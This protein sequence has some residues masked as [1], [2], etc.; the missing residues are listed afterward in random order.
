MRG[1]RKRWICGSVY[2]FPTFQLLIWLVS[3]LENSFCGICTHYYLQKMLQAIESQ[4]KIEEYQKYLRWKILLLYPLTLFNSFAL[5]QCGGADDNEQK[6]K[7]SWADWQERIIASHLFNKYIYRNGGIIEFPFHS[8][9]YVLLILNISIILIHAPKKVSV[10]AANEPCAKKKHTSFE[11][12][13][14]HAKFNSISSILHF[15]HSVHEFLFNKPMVFSLFHLKCKMNLLSL[16]IPNQNQVINSPLEKG[17]F[18]EFSHS[19]QTFRF[20]FFVCN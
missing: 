10:G 6:Q 20:V 8:C 7:Y 14:R 12:P 15:P 2:N 4:I 19:H 11:K 9:N 16:G 18:S 3:K 17:K 1:S 13:R 5:Q